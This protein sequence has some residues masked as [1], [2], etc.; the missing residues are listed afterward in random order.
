MIIA[1]IDYSMRGPSICIFAGTEKDTFSF[2]NC[3]FFYLT[4][5]LK[6]SNFYLN[7]IS[8]ERLQDYN[9]EVERYENNA[10]WAIDKVKG[11]DQIG[12]EGYAYSAKGKVFQIAENTGLLKYKLF[13]QGIP[14]E[15]FSPTEIK[16]F[17]TDKG[18]A[19]KDKMHDHFVKETKTNLIETI[20]PDKS[21]AINPVSDIVDSFY[22]C[23]YLYNNI[24]YQ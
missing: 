20:T 14:V 22:I 6:Y 9:H 18:N 11:C 24:K 12:L 19:N 8:G 3:R 17:A 13:Q 5:L 10:D 23:K 15:V 21:E 7:N 16:K 1:G 4:D 2:E